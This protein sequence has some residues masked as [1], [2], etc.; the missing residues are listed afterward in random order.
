MYIF[1]KEN[2][3]KK[4]ILSIVLIFALILTAGCKKTDE[5]QALELS[6]KYFNTIYNVEYNSEIFSEI[7]NEDKDNKINKLINDKTK[8]LEKYTSKE[9]H[10]IITTLRIVPTLYGTVNDLK[11]NLVV[12]SLEIK[13]HSK[14]SEKILLDYTIKLKASNKNVSETT[15]QIGLIKEDEKWKVN[16][17]S[18]KVL[19]DLLQR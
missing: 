8:D 6:E 7:Y 18:F 9:L 16:M 10:H 3:M 12:D 14:D 11:Q 1:T 5:E 2:H 17:D 15:G 4:S 19:M 13:I